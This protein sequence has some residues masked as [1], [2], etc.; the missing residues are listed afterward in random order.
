MH[1]AT[2]EHG[3]LFQRGLYEQLY[4]Y[5]EQVPDF[6]EVFGVGVLFKKNADDNEE[7]LLKAVAAASRLNYT[8]NHQ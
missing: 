4:S 8:R 7:Q 2:R 5:F 3:G 1:Y 6:T